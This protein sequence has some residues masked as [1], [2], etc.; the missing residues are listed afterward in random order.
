VSIIGQALG[1]ILILAL[2]T[3]RMDDEARYPTVVFN[4]FV[5]LQLFN[6]INARS[7][8]GNFRE[9]IRRPSSWF[10]G[11]WVFCLT[12]Q[13]FIVHFGREFFETTP[14]SPTEWMVGLAWA[15][16]SLPL[17]VGLDWIG[18]RVEAKKERFAQGMGLLPASGPSGDGQRSYGTVEEEVSPSL[19]ERAKRRWRLV[20]NAVRFSN[21]AKTGR[22]KGW[23]TIG[24]VSPQH[25]AQLHRAASRILPVTF[26]EE[27]VMGP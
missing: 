12:V 2:A 6:E 11:V 19:E 4:T 18:S 21:A 27:K 10:A 15:S 26:E 3:S 25:S 9:R 23:H 24:D 1:Q 16:L 13:F 7:L 8:T 5:L 14:L 20:M 22:A 17:Q